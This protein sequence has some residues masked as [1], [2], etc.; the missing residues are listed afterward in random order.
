MPPDEGGDP[1]KPDYWMADAF[2]VADQFIKRNGAGRPPL[3]ADHR[4]VAE[5]MALVA[6]GA[7]PSDAAA[8]LGISPSNFTNWETRGSGTD[9]DAGYLQFVELLNKAAQWGKNW[10]IRNI[11]HHAKRNWVAS[12][13]YLERTLPEQFGRRQALEVTHR[14]GRLLAG[15]DI[16][17]IPFGEA[18][19]S[20]LL[21]LTQGMGPAQASPDDQTVVG[22]YREVDPS[23]EPPDDSLPM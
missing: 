9:A 5:I 4:L 18:E 20:R 2:L 16:Q 7:A 22:D 1:T 15:Q 23:D 10:H 11:R 8:Q 3:L 17:T 12:A 19:A 13:W 21:A 6:E 14:N